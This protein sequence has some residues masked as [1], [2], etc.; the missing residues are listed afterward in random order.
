MQVE[1]RSVARKCVDCIFCNVIATSQTD[2]LV[3]LTSLDL[4]PKIKNLY[5]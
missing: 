4:N 3:L 2:V 1:K 5:R